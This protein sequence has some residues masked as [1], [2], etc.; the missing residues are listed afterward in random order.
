[1]SG[2]SLLYL[3]AL[4]RFLHKVLQADPSHCRLLSPSIVLVDLAVITCYRPRYPLVLISIPVS[5]LIATSIAI[6]VARSTTLID[7]PCP[8]VPSPI[9]RPC[10]GSY[11]RCSRLTPVL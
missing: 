3:Q 4:P 9:S 6:R 7:V 8:V 5:V 10:P 1:M 2:G 11:I